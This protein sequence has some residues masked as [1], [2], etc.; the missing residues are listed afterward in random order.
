MHVETLENAVRLDNQELMVQLV[1]EVYQALLGS[2][3]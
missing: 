2:Q 3:V 1:K